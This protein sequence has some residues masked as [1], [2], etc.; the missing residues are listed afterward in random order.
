[1]CPCFVP[2]QSSRCQLHT[3]GG[4][5]DHLSRHLPQPDGGT[6]GGTSRKAPAPALRLRVPGE[7]YRWTHGPLCGKTWPGT[8]EIFLLCRSDGLFAYQLAVVVDD[9]A[10]GITE[11]V[12]GADLLASTPRQ[13]YLYHL[14]G[15][16]LP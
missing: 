5:S 12:R 1:M 10:M 11:V 6:G 2:G 14:L 15:L 4:W 3:P 9:A 7:L 16:D 13:L 8:A